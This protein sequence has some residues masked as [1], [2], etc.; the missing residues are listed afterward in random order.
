MN[1]LSKMT[2]LIKKGVEGGEIK[3]KVGACGVG[4]VGGGVWRWGES[5]LFVE[6]S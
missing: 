1:K 4:V 5:V 2:Y 6:T 3:K